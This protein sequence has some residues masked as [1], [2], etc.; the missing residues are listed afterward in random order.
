MGQSVEIAMDA[1]QFDAISERVFAGSQRRRFLR[2]AGASLAGAL[3]TL[4][5]EVTIAK[6]GK[7]KKKGPAT[8][9]CSDGI[10]NG[11]EI[12]RDCGG[13]SCPPCNP[14]RVCAKNSD[15]GT[16]RCGDGQG[17][18]NICRS[19]AGDGVCGSDAN[20]GCLCNAT[21]GACITDFTP[22]TFLGEC[23]VCPP[24]SVCVEFFDG[25][26]CVPLCGG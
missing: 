26:A 23:P 13:P 16:A 22:T 17:S 6:K 24:R 20:G 21:L 4:N 5:G 14:G 11:A 3:F 7:K 18:G 12:D 8:P 25:F 9:T 1:K 15:C 2:I 19:C 10:K